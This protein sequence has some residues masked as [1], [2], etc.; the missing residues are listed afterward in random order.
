MAIPGSDWL[1]VPT[2]YKAY[3][4]GLFFR[5]YP[6]KIPIDQESY[7]VAAKTLPDFHTDSSVSR[8]AAWR[9]GYMNVFHAMFSQTNKGIQLYT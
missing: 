5:G 7:L 6:Q 9:S 1:E 3:F 8:L 4:W 2:I